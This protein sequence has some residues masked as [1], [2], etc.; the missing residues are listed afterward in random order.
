MK[1]CVH[2]KLVLHESGQM[3]TQDAGFVCCHSGAIVSDCR[4]FAERNTYTND[5]SDVKNEAR[6][7]DRETHFLG[8]ILKMLFHQVVASRMEQ[9]KETPRITKRDQVGFSR[10]ELDIQNLEQGDLLARDGRLVYPI[11][12]RGF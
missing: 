8:H 10:K 11:P 5:L 12:Q 9:G 2:V 7:C 1:L 3:R 6:A 4:V